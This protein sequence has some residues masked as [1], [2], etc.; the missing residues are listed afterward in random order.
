MISFI[1]GLDVFGGCSPVVMVASDDLDS[2]RREGLILFV[3]FCGFGLGC[4]L[5]YWWVNFSLTTL[6]DMYH[7]DLFNGSFPG[8]YT[9]C[10]VEL[11]VDF[12]RSVVDVLLQ[13]M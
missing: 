8:D 9:V 5:V 12:F 10:F 11:K 4:V 7:T 3:C 2:Q 1:A 13:D 6:G